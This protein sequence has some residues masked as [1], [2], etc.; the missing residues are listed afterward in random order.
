MKLVF[1]STNNSP[2]Y[3]TFDGDAITAHY[4]GDSEAFDLSEL[5]TGGRFDGVE[6]DKLSLRHRQIIRDAHRDDDGELHVTLCQAVGPGHWG[7]SEEIDVSKYDPDAIHVKYKDR[8]H[9]GVPWAKTRRG[10]VSPK[11]EE[12]I[13]GKG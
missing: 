8:K 5:E 4:K 12:V 2:D 10:K 7:R 1:I 11:T 6:P 13:G 9:S 3:Y